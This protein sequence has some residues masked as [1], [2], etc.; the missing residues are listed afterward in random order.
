MAKSISR[1]TWFSTSVKLIGVTK[2]DGQ[3]V[4]T[5]LTRDVYR[6]PTNVDPVPTSVG[7]AAEQS[8]TSDHTDMPFKTWGGAEANDGIS[9]TDGADGGTAF[10]SDFGLRRPNDANSTSE[11]DFNRLI[12]TNGGLPQD[13]DELSKPMARYTPQ[14]SESLPGTGNS[15]DLGPDAATTSVG[16]SYGSDLPCIQ[17]GEL[18]ARAIVPVTMPG[19]HGSE[20]SEMAIP[21]EQDAMSID[22]DIEPTDDGPLLDDVAEP[23]ADSRGLG[24]GEDAWSPGTPGLVIDATRKID[25]TDEA[26]ASDFIKDLEDKGLLEKLMEQHGYQKAKGILGE[27]KKPAASLPSPHGNKVRC[28]ECGKTFSRKCELTWV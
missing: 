23:S 19:A 28:E 5:K 1:V 2:Q 24:N 18:D 14:A 17:P 27:P 13:T 10:D 21:D 7:L 22:S 3:E 12:G 16:G 4:R 9:Q 20:P 15:D 6:D 8:P 26:A 11:L 25:L